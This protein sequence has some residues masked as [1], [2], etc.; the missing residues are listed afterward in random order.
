MTNHGVRLSPRPDRSAEDV[1][2]RKK[3][4]CL[5]CP[6]GG[7]DMTLSSTAFAFAR[8]LEKAPNGT[9]ES[10]SVGAVALAVIT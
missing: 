1:F 7:W 3:R 8:N 10:T 9:G 4:R 6:R 5:L 2:M